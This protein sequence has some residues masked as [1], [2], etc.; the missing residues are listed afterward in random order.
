MSD[1][2]VL[3]LCATMCFITIGVVIHLNAKTAAKLYQTLVD[4]ESVKKPKSPYG[5]VRE[6][7]TNGSWGYCITKDGKIMYSSDGETRTATVFARIEQAISEINIFEK[8][9]GYKVTKL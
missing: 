9:E 4:P 7:G 3:L 6:I 2:Q 1:I 8:L 5:I